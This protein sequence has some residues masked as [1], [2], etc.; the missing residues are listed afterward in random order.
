MMII[1]LGYKMHVNDSDSE[2]EYHANRNSYNTEEKL[3]DCVSQF[4]SVSKYKYFLVA[5]K[6]N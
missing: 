5:N 2:K 4:S 6:D 3:S 1:S